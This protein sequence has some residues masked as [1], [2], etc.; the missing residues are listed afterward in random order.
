MNTKHEVML[1]DLYAD[2]F[3]AVMTSAERS[4]RYGG[5]RIQTH[6]IEDHAERLLCVETIVW[7]FPNL[8]QV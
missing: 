4:S 1:E 5:G 2:G 8:F 7:V 6:L 3:D